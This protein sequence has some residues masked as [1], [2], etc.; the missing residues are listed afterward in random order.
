MFVKQPKPV[1]ARLAAKRK[2][3]ALKRRPLPVVKKRALRLAASSQSRP[4]DD[5]RKA[6]GFFPLNV[7]VEVLSWPEL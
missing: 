7:D 4:I 3:V 6:F 2:A 1:H 5:A